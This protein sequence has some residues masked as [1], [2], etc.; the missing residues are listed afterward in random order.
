MEGKRPLEGM[1]YKQ[2]VQAVC[3]DGLRPPIEKVFFLKF[4][5][6]KIFYE[7]KYKKK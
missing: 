4:I 5:E 1:K 2:V 6:S 7:K 3:F